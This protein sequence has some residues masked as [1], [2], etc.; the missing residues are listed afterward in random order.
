MQPIPL[1]RVNT[2]LPFVAFLHHLGAPTEKWLRQVK[3]PIYALDD[4]ETLIPRYQAFRFLEKAAREEGVENL[5]LLV[6][7]QTS[8]RKLGT[9]GRLICQSLTLYDAFRTCIQIAP[10]TNSGEVYWLVEQGERAWFCQQ[11]LNTFNTEYH[12]A[13][14]YSLMLMVDLI[15]MAAGQGWQPA[16]ICLQNSQTTDLAKSE[17]LAEPKIQAGVGFTGVAFPRSF[18]SLPLQSSLNSWDGQCQQER[19]NLYASA[20]VQDFASSLAQVIATLLRG[21]YPDIHL[22]SEIASMSARTLQRKLAQEGLT[23]SQIVEKTR[24]KMAIDYLQDPSLKLVN[25]AA[26]LGYTDAAHFTRA[27]KR[28]TGISPRQFRLNCF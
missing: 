21:G 12:Y 16:V 3:L 13:A 10:A 7:Q 15:R 24:L 27:F 2:V 17:L 1:I 19:E 5:G 11:Y 6:G 23:Y 20:P 26:E 25:I 22:A 4:P 28:W 14:H 9:F 8:V 18:L